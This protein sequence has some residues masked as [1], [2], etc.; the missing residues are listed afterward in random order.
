MFLSL[1]A[2][3][4]VSLRFHSAKVYRRAEPR[5]TEG[6]EACGA[7]QRERHQGEC[8]SPGPYGGP[9]REGSVPSAVPAQKLG[10]AGGMDP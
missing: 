2:H 9:Y 3:N 6:A 8:D 10:T 1:E 7:V 5:M 4:Q